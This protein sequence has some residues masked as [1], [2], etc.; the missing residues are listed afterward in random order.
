MN[1]DQQ[2]TIT[3]H[4]ENHNCNVFTAPMYNA[5]FHMPGSLPGQLQQDEGGTSSQEPVADDDRQERKLAAIKDMCSRLDNLEE[6]MLGHDHTGK[7]ISYDQL[8]IFL[9]RTLGMTDRGSKHEFVVIQEGIWTILIDSRFKCTKT[10]KETFFSQTFLNI[11]GYLIKQE[12]V[13]GKVQDVLDCLYKRPEASMR[14]CLERGIVSAFPE[15]TE[16]M[17]DFYIDQLKRGTL[18]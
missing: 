17:L 13:N 3:I 8:G 10:D 1:K 11:V 12:V 16:D 14:K 5:V 2:P 9:K 6:D 18:V 15:G 4:N 7:R